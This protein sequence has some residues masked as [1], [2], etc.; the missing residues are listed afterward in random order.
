VEPRLA[1]GD[2]A[3]GF[4]KALPQVFGNAREQRCWV[5]KTANVLNKLPKHLQAKAK[6]DLH[7]IWMADTRENAH[8]AF[9]VFL[10]SY[11]PKY[12][13]A[14]ECLAKDKEALLT[15][16]DFPAEHWIH[17]RTTTRLN[18]RLP[19]CG[20]APPRLADAYRGRALCR[21]CSN[22]PKAPSSGG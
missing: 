15:F 16:Y 22:L 7:P 6:S 21:C 3:L 4:C 20:C 9:D 1:I 8:L 13:K 18:R 2:G 12:P 17:I 5:H 10:Q 14:A 19:P 11:E